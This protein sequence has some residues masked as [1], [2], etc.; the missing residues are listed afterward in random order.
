MTGVPPVMGGTGW[1]PLG[2]PGACGVPGYCIGCAP[3]VASALRIPFGSHSTPTTSGSPV[4]DSAASRAATSRT[5][6]PR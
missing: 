5:S 1:L 2:W 4:V 6:I 3:A